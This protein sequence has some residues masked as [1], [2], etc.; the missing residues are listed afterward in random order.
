MDYIVHGIAKNR[1]VCVCV[2]VCEVTQ[3]CQTFCD[4]EDCSLPGSSAHRILQGRILEW[5][6]ILIEYINRIYFY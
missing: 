2:C 4:P 5:V 6:A 1:G 3:S